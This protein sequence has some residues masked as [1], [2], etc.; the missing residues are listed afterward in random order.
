MSW[1]CSRRAACW[2]FWPLRLPIFSRPCA[3]HHG[4]LSPTLTQEFSLNAG[5]SGCW[6]GLLSGVCRHPAAFGHLAGPPWPQ[7][8][9]PGVSGCGGGRLPGVFLGH[10]FLG[11]AGRPG[12]VRRGRQRLPDGAPDRLSPLVRAHGAVAHQFMDAH[13]RVVG[14]GRFHLAGAVA[15][16]LWR[17]ASAVLG[18]GWPCCCPWCH[19][20][21]GAALG[22]SD[23]WV[24]GKPQCCQGATGAT[25]PSGAIP[26][27]R[28]MTPIGFSATAA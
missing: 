4:H 9:D 12:A 3:R 1:A 15:G 14:H 17:V 5:I 19:C 21:A 16:P 18:S 13:D 22:G 27:F 2:S 10:Q 23:R 26:T 6:R 25:R 8:S 20:L 28:R 7:E 11:T 24:D